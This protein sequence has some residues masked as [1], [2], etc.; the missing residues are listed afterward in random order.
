MASPLILAS[1]SPGELRTALLVDGELQGAHIEREDDPE[2]LGDLHLGRLAARAPAMGGAFVALVGGVTGFLPDSEGAKGRSEGEWLPVLVTRTAQGGKGPRLSLRPGAAPPQGPLRLLSPGP[3]APARLAAQ[4]PGASVQTDSPALAARLRA[5]P[6]LRDRVT[7]LRGSAFDDAV[8]EEFAI[9][10]QAEVPLP[11]GGRLSLHPT[12]ALVAIDIDAGGLAGGRD[13]AAHR[14]LNGRALS[15]ALRQIRLRHLSGAILI[16]MAGLAIARRQ[17]LLPG[18]AAEAERDPLL[19][20]LGLTGLGLVELQRRRVHRP[21]HETLG[22]PLSPLTR[23]LA[24]LR[25]GASAARHAPGA[26]M[27]LRAAPAVVAALRQAPAA[28]AAF[29]AAAGPLRLRPDPLCAAGEEDVHA[30]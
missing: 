30:A 5:M 17:D 3:E 21:L 24:A 28:L 1:A 14:A 19:R 7:L 15:E 18:L 25:R 23:V 20:L 4:H 10:E 16:D 29:E 22:Q 11:G 6:R 12:P 2:G 13:A 27:E 26:A 8:E 9:L